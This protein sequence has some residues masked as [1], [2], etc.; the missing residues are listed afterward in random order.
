MLCRLYLPY[1]CE[2]SCPGLAV[3]DVSQDGCLYKVC[4]KRVMR[5]DIPQVVG[6]FDHKLHMLLMCFASDFSHLQAAKASKRA[7]DVFFL[8]NTVM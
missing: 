3:C 5:V 4:T 2:A 7:T 6:N 8:L 1:V